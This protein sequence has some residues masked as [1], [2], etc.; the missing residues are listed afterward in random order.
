[1]IKLEDICKQITFKEDTHQYFSTSGKEL[2]SVSRI[3][4]QFKNVFDPQGF[5]KRACARKENIS[6]AQIQEKWDKEKNDACDRGHR[7]HS[8]LEH[9]IKTGIIL[10]EDYKDVVEQFKNSVKFTG[11]LH[12]E[13]QLF[14]D[15]YGIAGTTDLVEL[16]DNSIVNIGDYKQNKKMLKK[17]KYGNNLLYPLEKYSECEFEI[18]VFQMNLYSYMLEE[19]GYKTNKMTLYYIPPSTRKL[20]IFD[21]PH[22]REDTLKILNHHQ[23][24]MDW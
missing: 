1:M 7:L 9:Y 18:Y 19:H 17:S 23:N 10:N 12:S 14:S 16:L 2:V 24:L 5:I 22:R 3:L 4:S 15:T 13:I 20:E 6:V 11:K 21:V 8:Q